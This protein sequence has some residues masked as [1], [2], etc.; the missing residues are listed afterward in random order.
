MVNFEELIT[1]LYSSVIAGGLAGCAVDF[2]LFPLDSI[3]TRI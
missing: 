2:A 1:I 3:K